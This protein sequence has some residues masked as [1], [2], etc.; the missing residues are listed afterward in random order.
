MEDFL[1]SPREEASGRFPISLEKKL[2]ED[3]LDIPREEASGGFSRFPSKRGFW[4]ISWILLEMRL[5]ED[6]LLQKLLLEGFVICLEKPLLS[7][8]V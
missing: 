5:L 6:F 1:D 7:E 3:V 8:L 2:L 4:Q